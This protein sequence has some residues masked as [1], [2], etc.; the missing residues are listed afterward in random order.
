MWAPQNDVKTEVV[1][2]EPCRLWGA[3]DALGGVKPVVQFG[4]KMRGKH[5]EKWAVESC[6]LYDAFACTT[7][8]N[9]TGGPGF[10][11]ATHVCTKCDSVRIYELFS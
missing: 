11:L 3:Q 5:K 4:M 9:L 1:D 8:G 2:L 10:V 6:D 7:C